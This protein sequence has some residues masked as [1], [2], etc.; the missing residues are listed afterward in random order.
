MKRITAMSAVFAG[1]NY[2]RR[3]AGLAFAVEGDA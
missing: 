1:N 3:Q 2:D